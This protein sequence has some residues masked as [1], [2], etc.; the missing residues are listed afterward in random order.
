MKKPETKLGEK[1]DE[2]LEAV[3]GEWLNI[4]GGPFQKSGW[5]DRIGCYKGVFI[6][7]ELKMPGETPTRLQLRR[8]RRINES[9]GRAVVCYSLQEVKNFISAVDKFAAGMVQ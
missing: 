3:G 8:I 1:V 9:G 5:P 7:I 6:G 2:Y 4:H